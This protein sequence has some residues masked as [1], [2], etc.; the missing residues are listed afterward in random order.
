[1]WNRGRLDVHPES[2]GAR[3]SCIVGW[4]PDQLTGA[5]AGLPNEQ[6]TFGRAGCQGQETLTQHGRA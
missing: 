5:T 4:S 6:E 3:V 1:M 2:I